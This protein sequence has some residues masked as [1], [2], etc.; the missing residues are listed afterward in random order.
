[1]LADQLRAY[2]EANGVPSSV[3]GHA[4]VMTH[5]FTVDGLGARQILVPASVKALAEELLDRAERGELALDEAEDQD[6]HLLPAT[7]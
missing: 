5:P 6:P 1:M 3:R 4:P 7:K 2:L